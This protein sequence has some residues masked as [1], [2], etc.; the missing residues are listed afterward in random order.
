MPSVTIIVS[1]GSGWSTAWSLG[2]KVKWNNVEVERVT[3]RYGI[4]G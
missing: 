1:A 2:W 3:R 4:C